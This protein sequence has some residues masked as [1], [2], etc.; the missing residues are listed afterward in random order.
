MRSHKILN[1]IHWI[2]ALTL[3]LLISSCGLASSESD[4]LSLSSVSLQP[5]L[6]VETGS[7]L[8]GT[9]DLTEEPTQSVNECLLCHQDKQRLIDSAKPE[10]EVISENTGQG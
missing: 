7:I 6:D 8:P 10:E 5:Q 2:K 1:R 9:E 4:I 3:C